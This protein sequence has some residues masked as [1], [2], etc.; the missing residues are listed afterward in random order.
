MLP[1]QWT[2]DRL[3]M[4]DVMDADSKRLLAIFNAN[5][6]IGAWDPTFQPVPQAEMDGVV[7]DSLAGRNARGYAFQMQAICWGPAGEHPG[8]VI[9]YYHLIF[10]APKPHLIWISLM[11][12]DPAVQ[13]RRCGSEML[14]GLGQQL[15]ALAVYRAVWV[16]V[17]LKNW[18]ALR[19]WT[20]AGFDRII[21][22]GGD[23]V[24]TPDGNANVVL[25]QELVRGREG[26]R[27]I[28]T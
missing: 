15:R 18:P 12:F 10:G 24:L 7:A 16:E 3:L 20:K 5:A 4:R 11:V 13:N 14:A 1:E 6:H 2:T 8:A 23:P 22:I 27:V 17:W 9:G 19:L 28:V 26:E 21:K 25:E